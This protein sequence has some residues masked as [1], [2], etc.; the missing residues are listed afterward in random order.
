[1][2]DRIASLVTAM[3]RAGIPVSLSEKM[4]A[5]EAV[6][7]APA[8]RPVIRNVLAA[9]LIKQAEH[10]A[11][12][13]LL[14]DLHFSASADQATAAG[15][16]LAGSPVVGL[17]GLSDDDLRS[18]IIRALIA[19]ERIT[20]DRLASEAVRRW[21]GF[22]P[23]RPVGG[24]YYVIR[25]L[26]LLD[27]EQV[28]VD[29]TSVVGAERQDSHL[30][31]AVAEHLR[32][33]R[34]EQQLASLRE[35]VEHAVRVLLVSDRGAE[36]VAASTPHR[37]LDDVDLT[38]PTRNE[39]DLLSAGLEPLARKLAARMAHRNGHRAHARID[40]RRTLR[41]SLAFGGTPVDI[42]TRPR[43]PSRPDLVIIADLSGSMAAFSRFTLMLVTA[44]AG[45]FHRVRCFGF[46]DGII[47]ITERV[48]SSDFAAT[49][50]SIDD[51]P[52]LRWFDGHSDYGHAFQAFWDQWGG[53]LHGRCTV[54]VVGDARNNY[55]AANEAYLHRIR[56]AVQQVHWLNPE[57]RAGW[58]TGD[59][60]I[61][62]YA[63]DCD[64]V[65]EVRTRRQ[66]TDYIEAIA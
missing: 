30:A 65:Q 7:L 17:D 48:R 58:N 55:H 49:V 2:H 46:V 32:I 36:A 37:L 25:T 38:N 10:D 47:E 45:Q 53:E 27:E 11:L 13:E 51:D 57:P 5:L 41:R 1:L 42:R 39:L 8:S 26:R 21:S 24:T 14:F 18:A 6:A 35:A 44:L 3:R 28:R 40:I 66:L 43:R 23:G 4:D 33:Q 63:A 15:P 52:D 62:R 34:I 22:Q 9:T 16:H 31:A 29:P 64:L 50:R 59:S 60:V 19:G 56:R 12:Y 61:D 54:I 20:L